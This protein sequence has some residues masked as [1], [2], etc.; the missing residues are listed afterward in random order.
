MNILTFDIEEWWHYDIY[1]TEDKWDSYEPR[2]D[3]YLDKVLDALDS[4]NIKATCFCLGWIARKYPG[5]I[6]RIAERGHEIA[7]HT[8]RHIFVKDMNPESF[9]EDLKNALDI[10]ENISGKKIKSFRAPSFTI[11]ENAKW[12]FEVLAN[13]G[14]EYDCSIFPTTRSYGGFPSFGKGKPTLIKHNGVEIKEFPINTGKVLG[15]DFVFG[16]GGY[17][18]LFPYWLIKLLMQQSDY[19]MTYLHMRDFDAEQHRFTYFDFERK[20]KSYYGLK[21]TYSK[22]MQFVHDYKWIS[23]EEAGNQIDWEKVKQLDI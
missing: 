9:N 4:E 17:F 19:N 11:T 6:K 15:K 5:V 22:F 1:S 20:F 16:G 7:C 10:L 23:V 12:A 14:I 18:R 3:L 2:I 21:G 13:N 8:D